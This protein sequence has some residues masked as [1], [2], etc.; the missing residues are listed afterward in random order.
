[1]EGQGW[2]PNS[3]ILL[4]ESRG[5]LK[6]STMKHVYNPI[7]RD[8]ETGSQVEISLGHRERLSLKKK[9]YDIQH[10]SG[11]QLPYSPF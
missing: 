6:L 5:S 10:S 4:P 8:V 1:M 11:P 3:P 9:F 2:K 7:T